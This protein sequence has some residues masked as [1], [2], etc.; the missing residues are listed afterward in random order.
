MLS[1][2]LDRASVRCIL[3]ERSHRRLAKTVK[4]RTLILEVIWS[5]AHVSWWRPNCL[6][7][8]IGLEIRNP[9]ASH[10]IEIS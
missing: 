5:H 2:A 10:V 6:A 3:P 8:V 7:G 1:E 4:A 9:C